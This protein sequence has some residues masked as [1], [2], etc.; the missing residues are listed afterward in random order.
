MILDPWF[1]VLAVPALMIVGISKGGFGSGLG[2]IAVPMRAL[3][4]PVPP[5]AA[6]MLPLRCVMDLGSLW[7]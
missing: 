1:Y 3:T 4:V 5:A 6:S 2:L 7:T